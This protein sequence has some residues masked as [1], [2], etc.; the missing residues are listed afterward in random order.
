[1]L[2]PMV[3]LAYSARRMENARRPRRSSVPG[4]KGGETRSSFRFFFFPTLFFLRGGERKC[5]TR[6]CSLEVLERRGRILSYNQTKNA[7]GHQYNQARYLNTTTS[8]AC[9]PGSHTRT[10]THTHTL[11]HTRTNAQT[12]THVCACLRARAHTHTHTHTRTR[13]LAVAMLALP[14]IS[15]CFPRTFFVWSLW[16]RRSPSSSISWT[17][18]IK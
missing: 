4:K 6:L 16:L 5:R 10:Y 14:A 12:H 8:F 11:T 3:A 13:R 2:T 17:N 7:I 18:F 1:M 15:W 9:R